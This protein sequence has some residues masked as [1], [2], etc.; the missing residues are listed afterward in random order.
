MLTYFVPTYLVCL[1]V[2]QNYIHIC[3]AHRRY[4]IAGGCYLTQGVA[5]NITVVTYFTA[6][7]VATLPTERRCPHR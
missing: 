5:H 6:T 1:M 4:S 3:N 2:G 7:A